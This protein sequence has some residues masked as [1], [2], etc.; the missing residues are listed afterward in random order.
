MPGAQN[1]NVVWTATNISEIIAEGSGGA[2]LPDWVSIT[3]SGTSSPVTFEIVPSRTNLTVGMHNTTL[4]I[5]AKNSAGTALSTR[6]VDINYEITAGTGGGGGG[7]NGGGS[8][9]PAEDN[10]ATQDSIFHFGQEVVLNGANVAWSAG[11]GNWYN[12][13][14]GA[15]D[16]NGN[17]R[18][19]IA[20]FQTHFQTIANAGGNSARIWLHTASTV[21]PVIQNDG[22]VTGLSRNL[23]DA[24]V[25]AQ[26]DAI[27]DAAWDEG[28][29]VTFNLFSFNMLCDQNAPGP[30]KAMLEGNVQSY[31]DNALTPMVSGV[32]DHPAMFAWD[33]FNEPEGMSQINY[34]CPSS[35]IITTETVQQVVNQT[36]AAIHVLD[37]NVKVTISTHTDLYDN[38]SNSTLAAI[39]N[40]DAGG[41]MDFYS[42]HWY[43]TGW[44]VSP[45]TTMAGEFSADRPVIMSEFGVDDTGN[46]PTPQ[47]SLRN[48]LENGYKGAWPWSLTTGS[49]AD[50]T[51]SITEASALSGAIDKAAIET[52]IQD[53]PADCYN[54]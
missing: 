34:F 22:S 41:T 27:L 48:I 6:S 54:P 23:T 26:L 24:Q 10:R 35:D 32:K 14:I 13:D 25:V 17:P 21:T 28:I 15:A 36:A 44:Q 8:A 47:N 42:L 45:H 3:K 16:G 12:N 43:D 52:C 31:I 37:P 4:D 2:A 11:A 46:N 49:V 19:N 9:K 30:A 53:K 5:V 50:I 51:S 39:P 33:I 20:A 18:T 7:G 29:L 40:A 1:I 38:Y